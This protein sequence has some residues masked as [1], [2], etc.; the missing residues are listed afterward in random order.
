[1]YKSIFFNYNLC[2]TLHTHCYIHKK[3]EN[4]TSITT[5]ILDCRLLIKNKTNIMNSQTNNKTIKCDE[6]GCRTDFGRTEH[7]YS[8]SKA[9]KCDEC[10]CRTDL[11]RAEHKY[12]CSKAVKCDECGCRTDL[13]RAEHKSVCSKA[14]KCS[15]CGHR[16]DLGMHDQHTFNCSKR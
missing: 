15:E 1:M 10:G 12:V 3:I 13:G 11:G 9:V 4:K 16:T 2:I 5:F 7:T 8:C 14:V 6:C